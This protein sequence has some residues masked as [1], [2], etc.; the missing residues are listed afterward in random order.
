VIKASEAVQVAIAGAGS[1]ASQ[2]EASSRSIARAADDLDGVEPPG[3]AKRLNARLVGGFRQLARTFHAAA[4]AARTGD[5]AKRDDILE[6]LDQS[7]GLRQLEAA[8][9]ELDKLG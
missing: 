9:R 1:Q 4:E 6:H 8:E 7:P 3:E 5:F 2:L